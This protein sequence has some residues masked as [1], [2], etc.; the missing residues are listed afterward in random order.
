MFFSN[1]CLHNPS[2]VIDGAENRCKV[3]KIKYNIGRKVSEILT[4]DAISSETTKLYR[5][6]YQTFMPLPC[7]MARIRKKEAGASIRCTCSHRC[8]THK[9]SCL[10]QEYLCVDSQY[11]ILGCHLLFS[12]LLS[13]S[14]TL[15]P[16]T[17]STGL[18]PRASSLRQFMVTGMRSPG[19][20]W[21]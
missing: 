14:F 16:E 9:A 3:T 19:R 8:S 12:T 10:G 15:K 7:P 6:E 1:I 11:L 20:R 13:F 2:L 18:V 21:K 17:L 4:Y 5:K